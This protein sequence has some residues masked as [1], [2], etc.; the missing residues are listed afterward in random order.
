MTLD[1]LNRKFAEVPARHKEVSIIASMDDEPARPSRRLMDIALK[2]VSVAIDVALPIYEGRASRE[3]HWF[4]TWPGEHYRLL[5]AL[6]RTLKPKTVIEIGTF[7]GMGT[8]A[9]AQELQPS[10]TLTTF[11]LLA[12]NSFADTWLAP[13]DFSEGRVR[14]VLHDISTPG[15]I[16]PHRALFES[17]DLIFVDGPKDGRTEADILVN[18]S[19][20]NLSRDAVVVFDDIR[21]VNMIDIWRRVA[22]P[23]MDLTSFGHWSGTGL[24]DWNGTSDL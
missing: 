13:A 7:T 3:P 12:W 14:Q 22:Q 10:G 2:A 21:V 4:D 24:I 17:A 20:L 5:A 8:L 19:T 9:L 15:G 23:K 18:L 1:E 6:V 11:D 16:E